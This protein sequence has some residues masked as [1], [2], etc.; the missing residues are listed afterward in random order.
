[1]NKEMIEELLSE[2]SKVRS[3]R[4]EDLENEIIE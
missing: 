3:E 1:V 2:R 4:D